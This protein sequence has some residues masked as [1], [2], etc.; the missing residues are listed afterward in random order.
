M[1]RRRILLFLSA[2]RCEA[3]TWRN[4]EL[5]EAAQ[6]PHDA[7]GL[8][9]FTAFVINTG[10]LASL[11]VD[12]VEE[13]FRQESV[14]HLRGSERGALIRRKLEQHYR[15]TPFRQAITLQR[16]SGG[17][18]DDDMLFSAL[19]NPALITPWLNILQAHYIPLSGIYSIPNVSVRLIQDIAPGCV[20]LLSWEK[21]A[22]LR[23][24]FFDAALLRFSRLTPMSIGDSFG[25]TAETETARTQLYLKNLSLLPPGQALNVSIIC[26]A[27]Q[28]SELEA[29]LTDDN[30]THYTYLDIG[31]LGKHY[32]S[33]SV[34]ADSDAT[35][36]Y[37]H[38][39]AAR[40]PPQD[41]AGAAHLHSLKLLQLRRCLLALS[42][43]LFMAGSL[44][45]IVAIREAQVLQTEKRELATQTGQRLQQTR[46]ILRDLP[47]T[48]ASAADMK[49]AVNLSRNLAGLSPPPQQILNELGKTLSDFP[50]LRIDKLAWHTGSEIGATTPPA[51]II[52]LSGEL[53][54][55]SGSYRGALDYLEQFRLALVQRGYSV[56]V[57][58]L[59]L[60]ISPQGSIAGDIV[61]GSNKPAHFSLH[62]SWRKGT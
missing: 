55:F 44:W 51:Q 29:H 57:L 4:G 56:T 31:E 60:D 48:A 35:P 62:L 59:P 13:D 58:T 19:T 52:L 17:R 32:G 21:S 27:D 26:H 25:A 3:W 36:L 37:L 46:L 38:L 10:G 39:L 47:D 20:L 12:L 15:N 54:P 6:F 49:T 24:T 43:I 61:D 7:A 53:P 50:A 34:Y 23:Q 30:E 9:L 28:R 16:Q 14:P 40:P 1:S 18:C 8:E 11:L 22:G 2:T 41:Y 33:K 5:A 42:A 45:C